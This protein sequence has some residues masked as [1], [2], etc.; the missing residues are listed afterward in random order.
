MTDL[1]VPSED[2]FTTQAQIHLDIQN[3]L[4]NFLTHFNIQHDIIISKLDPKQT[5]QFSEWWNNLSKCLREHAD[6]HEQLALHLKNAGITYYQTEDEVKALF[7]P[8]S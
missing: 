2:R 3:A 8:K 4:L 1:K 5:A 6:L 7:M